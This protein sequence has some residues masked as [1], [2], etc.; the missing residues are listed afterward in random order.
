MRPIL[1]ILL[2]ITLLT[3]A[4]QP[5][6]LPQT[7]AGLTPT[8]LPVAQN[9]AGALRQAAAENNF[10]ILFPALRTARA[11]RWLRPA[12]RVTYSLVTATFGL[13]REDTSSSGAGL[14]QYDVIS[15]NRRN[16]AF[17]ATF[18]NTQIQGT[19]PVQLAHQVSIPGTGDF[20]ISPTVLDNAEAVASDSFL[21]TRM[22]MT[23]E[24]EQYDVV[25]MQSNTAT[26]QGSGEE[27]WAFDVESGLLVFYRQAL[28]GRDGSQTSGT[29]ATLLGQ[30]QI[31]LPWRNGT[32]PDWVKRGVNWQFAGSHVL[33][34]GVG[35]PVP[36]SMV[37]S[38]RVTSVGALWSVHAQSKSLQGQI[39]STSETLN[40]PMQIFGAYWL[41]PEALDVLETG[42]I[43]DQ[44]PISDIEVSV[45]QAN[46]QQIVMQ[47]TGPGHITQLYYNAT[48]GQLIGI[49]SEE[50]TPTSTLTTSLEIVR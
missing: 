32:L 13:T 38:T 21:V 27:V 31:R 15:Q 2:L 42:D 11:P 49:Y 17:L 22:P 35:N 40:G 10:V 7:L 5:I 33:D 34:V 24:G 45:A 20:W 4:C 36:L 6:I 44:D 46:R 48:T 43:L 8:S 28:Y 30:R 23:V 18:I 3:T 1:S 50:H 16:V 12:T 37:S 41:P 25:R 29:T 26:N 19:L 9:V 39:P 47:A 14:L